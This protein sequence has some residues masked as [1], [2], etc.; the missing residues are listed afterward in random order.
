MAGAVFDGIIWPLVIVLIFAG[1][2]VFKGALVQSHDS[3]AMSCP[4]PGIERKLLTAFTERDLA[5]GDVSH[6][7]ERVSRRFDTC[8]ASLL[9]S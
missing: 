4:G 5:S 3:L 2:N 7:G 6:D 1:T 9:K 8:L